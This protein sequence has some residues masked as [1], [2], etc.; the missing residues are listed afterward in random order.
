MSKAVFISPH[1]DDVCFSMAAT[2]LLCQGGQLINVFTQSDYAVAQT[3]LF[4]N[5][6]E[7]IRYVTSLRTREDQI[8]AEA[9]NLT[10]HDLMLEEPSL[11]DIHPF[12]LT[13]S[14][15]EAKRLDSILIDYVIGL[16]Q[17]NIGNKSDLF[18]PMGIGGHRDHVSVLT[19]V[20][21]ALPRLRDSYNLYFYEDLHYASR[22]DCR[23]LGLLRF[24]RMLKGEQPTRRVLA[25]TPELFIRKMKLVSIYSS[26]HEGQPRA[27]DFIP[28]AK[29]IREPHEAVWALSS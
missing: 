6:N 15:I 19:A 27:S 23:N 5:R 3:P 24:S 17:V 2:A 11:I 7:R 16:S 20:V 13:D 28:A 4:E 25:L 14:Q 26:Q 9:C 18:C 21:N 10:R 12:D 1:H 22:G 29:D 8:F